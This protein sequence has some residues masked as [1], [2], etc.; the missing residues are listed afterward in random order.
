[1]RIVT[2]NTGCLPFR[3]RMAVRQGKLRLDFHVTLQAGR[4]GPSRIVNQVTPLPFHGVQASR[5]VAGFTT[6]IQAGLIIHHQ[7]GMCRVGKIQ[8]EVFM[9]EHAVLSA[10]EFGTSRLGYPKDGPVD[11]LAGYQTHQYGPQTHPHPLGQGEP[12]R[13]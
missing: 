4:G 8:S 9:A 3:N 1:V 13:E 6:H 10:N 5:T 12:D 2:I 7:A 11:R